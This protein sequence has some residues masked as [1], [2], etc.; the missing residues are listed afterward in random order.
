MKGARVKSG[1]PSG[2][3]KS[4][5]KVEQYLLADEMRLT[6]ASSRLRSARALRSLRA[7]A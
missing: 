2:G 6:R 1:R 7:A 4:E 3:P 5:M